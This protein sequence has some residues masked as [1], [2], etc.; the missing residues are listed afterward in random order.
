MTQ[1]QPVPDDKNW[2]WVLE[3][4][5]P[6][7]GYDVS[8]I[9]QSELGAQVRANAA[10]WRSVL[11]RGDIV[12]RRPPDGPEGPVW[13]ALEYGAHV[14][15][16]YQ[17]FGERMRKMLKKKNPSFANWDPNV[18]ALKE[19]YQSQDPGKVAYALARNA[20]EFA[21]L[22]DRVADDEWARTGERSDGSHFTV[23]SLAYYALHDP[24]HHLWDVEQG[25]EKL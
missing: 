9:P 17:L 1:T 4:A 18:T 6:D 22:L 11:Q 19:D 12:T 21:D 5:C 25:F 3:R 23:E 20:G 8:T 15:D 14:R 24:I 2:T 7:C 13:S 16:V 10:S